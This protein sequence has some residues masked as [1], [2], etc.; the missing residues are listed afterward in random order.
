V[1]EDYLVDCI[2]VLSMP[3]TNPVPAKLEYAYRLIQGY[4][5]MIQLSIPTQAK[6]K[7]NSTIATV[8]SSH[9]AWIVRLDKPIAIEI[10]LEIV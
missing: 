4:E 6:Q 9:T 1:E 3:P 2:E 5:E 10:I 7:L 8:Q